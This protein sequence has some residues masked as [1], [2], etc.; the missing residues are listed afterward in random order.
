MN[1]HNLL[2]VLSIV[3]INNKPGGAA[4]SEASERHHVARQPRGLKGES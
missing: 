2:D 4:L 3:D 1:S